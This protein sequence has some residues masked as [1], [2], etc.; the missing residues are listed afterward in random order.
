LGWGFG[1]KIDVNDQQYY[2][3]AGV[4]IPKTVFEISVKSR[5]LAKAETRFL[6][7]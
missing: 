6:L 7:K 4:A 3:W 2:S 5:E 1:H